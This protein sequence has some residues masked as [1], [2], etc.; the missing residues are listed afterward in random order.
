MN[1]KKECGRCCGK[2][3]IPAF[4]HVAGGTCFNCMGRGFFV[5][6]D[7]TEERKQAAQAKREAIAAARSEKMKA[8]FAEVVA[9]MNATFGPFEVATAMGLDALNCAVARATGKDLGQHR[10]QRI[11]A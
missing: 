8:A 11:A 1:T 3:Y 5:V 9:E 6:N 10:N 7:A 4:G 2:G